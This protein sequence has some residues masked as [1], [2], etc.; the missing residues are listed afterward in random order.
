MSLPK[1]PK[2][3][4]VHEEDDGE[5]NLFLVAH[6]DYE[7]LAD[8]DDKKRVAVYRIDKMVTLKNET[9]VIG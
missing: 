4:Y 2:T 3:I 7:D 5:G 8:Q 1:Y 6:R 9:K